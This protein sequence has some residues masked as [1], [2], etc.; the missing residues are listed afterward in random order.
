LLVERQIPFLSPTDNMKVL[1]IIGSGVFGV[2]ELV[3]YQN[4]IYAHK[5]SQYNVSKQHNGILEEAIKLTDTTEYHPN[6]QR[7]YFINLKTFGF[8]MD[9]CGGGSLDVFVTDNNSKYTFVDVLNWGYQLA[10]ALSFL[11][12]KNISKLIIRT[13][14]DTRNLLLCFHSA[15]RC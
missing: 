14:L 4:K 8:L 15:S 3:D 1:K 7:L 12:S 11:H 9:Y 6:I 2:V 10:D 13:N 5:R